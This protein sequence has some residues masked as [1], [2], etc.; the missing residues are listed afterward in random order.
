MEEQ[1]R[2][3]LRGDSAQ[4]VRSPEQLSSTF[5][6]LLQFSSQHVNPSSDILPAIVISPS[7]VSMVHSRTFVGAGVMGT[8]GAGVGYQP[9]LE[10]N[11]IRW[12]Y[13]HTHTHRGGTD[14]HRKERGR[15]AGGGWDG[16][17]ERKYKSSTMQQHCHLS[18]FEQ[19]YHC[20]ACWTVGA[21]GWGLFCVSSSCQPVNNRE[22]FS[23]LC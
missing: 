12:A 18:R 19:L 6:Q 20:C 2:T 21:D 9:V 17:I 13:T 14:G 3:F 1:S 16:D 22:F 5:P 8:A 15:G 10:K 4:Q 7:A 11:A 23:C